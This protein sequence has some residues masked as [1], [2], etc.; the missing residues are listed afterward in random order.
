MPLIRKA[1]EAYRHSSQEQK[2]DLMPF[3]F[4]RV[5]RTAEGHA[6]FRESAFL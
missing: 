3:R 4:H 5:F 2:M 6:V 1:S